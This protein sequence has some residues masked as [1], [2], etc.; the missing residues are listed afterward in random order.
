MAANTTK[1]DHPDE[2]LDTYDALPR[3]VRRVV[4]ESDNEWACGPLLKHYR[5]SGVTAREYADMLRKAGI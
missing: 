2:S 5:L 4:R 3:E 1:G